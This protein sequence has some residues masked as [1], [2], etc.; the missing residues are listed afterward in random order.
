[1]IDFVRN[2]TRILWAFVE[3]AFAAVLAVMLIHLI[4]GKSAGD[5][6]QSVADNVIGF[7]N[8]IPN[9]SLIGLA[10][11]LGLIYLIRQRMA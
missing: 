2:A 7:A 4:L 10:V 1:M 3:L 8:A 5:F 11:V 6:V 9:S